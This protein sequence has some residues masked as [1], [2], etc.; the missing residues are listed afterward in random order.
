MEG[1]WLSSASADESRKRKRSLR[2]RSKARRI[3]VS[4]K[5]RRMM[6]A[7]EDAVR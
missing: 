7:V 3:S 4:R 6:E 2:N 5:S 1:S